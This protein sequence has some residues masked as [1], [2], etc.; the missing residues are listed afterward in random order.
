MQVPTSS[1]VQ[2]QFSGEVT[3]GHLKAAYS[4][5]FFSPF[6]M[7]PLY[8]LATCFL[9]AVIVGSLRRFSFSVGI[10]TIVFFVGAGLIYIWYWF[11]HVEQ[12]VSRLVKFR[13]WLLGPVHGTFSAAFTTIWHRD[14]GIQ[15]VS[16]DLPNHLRFNSYVVSAE[17]RPFS[18]V[19]SSCFF[20]SDWHFV[21]DTLALLQTGFL[22]NI[23]PAN[24]SHVCILQSERLS[25]LEMRLRGFRWWPSVGGAS[26]MVA[27][28][29]TYFILN[30]FENP[31]SMWLVFAMIPSLVLVFYLFQV[32]LWTWHTKRQFANDTR[33]YFSVAES[34]LATQRCHT[35]SWFNR[36]IVFGCAGRM[37]IHFPV[38]FVEK[39][40]IGFSA[41]EFR[42]RGVDMIFH[43]EGFQNH[44]AWLK[45]LETAREIGLK[46]DN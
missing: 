19:P 5:S 1:V 16:Q 34:E 26:W 7:V 10:S 39:V 40:R 38:R 45:A 23:P 24:G 22:I 31:V 46:A 30:A 3:E 14:V 21:L 12:R 42:A 28:V 36:E 6:L 8:F 29:M 41:I 2:V 11:L 27:A 4:N 25:F 44:A 33:G 32:S 20:E 17:R 37:W 18:I 9:V 35:V 13:P 43:R 15:L